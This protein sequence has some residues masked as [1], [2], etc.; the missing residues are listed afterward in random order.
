MDDLKNR[1]LSRKFWLA[2]GAFI[3]LCANG[4]YTEAVFVVSTYIGVEGTRDAVQTYKG[5]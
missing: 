2:V 5:E 3:T 1:L 4:Q